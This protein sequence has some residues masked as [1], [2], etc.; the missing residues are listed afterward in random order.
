[1][2]VLGVNLH[3]PRMQSR[4]IMGWVGC[5]C[6]GSGCGS[7]DRAVASDSRGPWFESGHRQILYR[8]LEHLFTFYCT[9]LKTRIKKRKD[10]RDGPFLKLEK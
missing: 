2:W 4:A 6:V 3:I 9:V 7:V 1:M 8:T 5:D 10:A